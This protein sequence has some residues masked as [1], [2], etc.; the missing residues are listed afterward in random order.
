MDF[1]RL[2]AAVSGGASGLGLATARRIAAA[3]GRVLLLDV[4]PE[5]GERA[6]AALGEGAR[7]AAVDVTDA[8]APA[9]PI[10]RAAQDWG[11]LDL[12]VC[13]AGVVGVGGTMGKDGPVPLD[14]F[15]RTVAVNL[16]GTY[17]LVRLAAPVMRE[18]PPR[19]DGERGVI[20]MTASIAGYEGQIGHAAYAASKA[21][22]IGM[23]LPLARE[24]ARYGIR[25][26][27][28][29]PGL[30]RTPMLESLGPAVRERLAQGVPF[31][32]RL[33]EPAEY[34]TLVESIVRQPMLN[35]ETIRYDAALRLA[36]R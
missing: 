29:A 30:F 35:G 23:T 22:V 36:P 33:G 7:F 18:N 5:Q 13:C 14:T 3:G 15:A 21:G 8:D 25:V 11:G 6:A 2:R 34:A 1:E 9:A 32:S 26:V 31:P 12:L 20:V 17:N 4:N 16:I 27:S 10:A 24:F 28:I 19:A